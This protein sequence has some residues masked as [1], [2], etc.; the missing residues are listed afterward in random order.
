MVGGA[1]V[2]LR[3]VG[4]ARDAGR[5]QTNIVRINQKRQV[6]IPIYRQPGADTIQIVN[7]I[8]QRLQT[9]G[10]RL[11]DMNRDNP[12]MQSLVL[13]VVMDQSLGVRQSITGLQVAAGLG[14]LLAGLVVLILRKRRAAR[15]AGQAAV[16]GG[17]GRGP[18]NVAADPR[19]DDHVLRGLACS[20]FRA[21]SRMSRKGAK[22]QR[23]EWK[24]LRPCV[25]A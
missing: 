8:K 4:V 6:Y 19:I 9:I 13:S 12:K 17:V 3:H 2:L 24:P 7:S 10:D 22:A 14:A 11:K 16:R 18:G 20:W 15:P 25:F 5:I 23:G 21:A 1:P